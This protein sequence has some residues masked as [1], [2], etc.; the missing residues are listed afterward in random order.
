MCMFF[1]KYLR[2]LECLPINTPFFI[3]VP[4]ILIVLAETQRERT[5]IRKTHR[6]I[7]YVYCISSQTSRDIGISVKQTCED[8]CIG[9]S[10]PIVDDKI[11]YLVNALKSGKLYLYVGYLFLCSFSCSKLYNYGF[12]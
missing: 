5:S 11:D 10:I 6:Y 8:F 7:G 1:R 4:Y 12:C 9:I 3:Y 2:N